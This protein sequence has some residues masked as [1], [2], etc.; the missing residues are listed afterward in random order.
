VLSATPDGHG[1]IATQ[2]DFFTVGEEVCRQTR[3]G[4]IRLTKRPVKEGEE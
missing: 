1:V 2:I 4:L 3:E